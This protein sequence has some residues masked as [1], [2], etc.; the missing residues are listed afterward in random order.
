MS[1]EIVPSWFIPNTYAFLART[2]AMILLVRMEDIL[3][4]E[5]QINLPGTYLQYPN[6]RY[7][8]P[9][10]LEG[11]ST[12]ERMIHVCEIINKERPL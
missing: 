7:K 1:G 9:I 2:N 10:L 11:L 4:Q 6:W 12:D 3:Q 8:L 5:E